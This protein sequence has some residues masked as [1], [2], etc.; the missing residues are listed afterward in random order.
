MHDC[1]EKVYVTIT[2]ADLV[3]SCSAC[4][5]PTTGNYDSDWSYDDDGAKIKMQCVNCH[6][7]Q[8]LG[9]PEGIHLSL[10]VLED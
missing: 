2:A 1:L 7:E 6:S 5:E 4:G 8:Y 10:P 9:L 3:G